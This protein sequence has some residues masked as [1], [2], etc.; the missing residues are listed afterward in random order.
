VQDGRLFHRESRISEYDSTVMS[1]SRDGLARRTSS[2]E[3]A[4]TPAYRF[5]H[6]ARPG[7]SLVGDDGQTIRKR[8]Q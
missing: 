4:N 8:R 7:A 3:A 2:I 1:A 6:A 5:F